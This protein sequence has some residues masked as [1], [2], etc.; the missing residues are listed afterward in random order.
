MG[1]SFSFII[2]KSFTINSVI[3][4]AL[5]SSLL[6][7]E[8]WL[9]ENSRW[10]IFDTS[11]T[12]AIN[13]FNPN[14]PDS[15][16]IKTIQTEQCKTAYGFSLFQFGYS[17]ILSNTNGVGTL[18]ITNWVFQNFFYS[19]NSFVGLLNGH[20][21]VSIIG[22]TFIKFS[23]WGSIIRDTAEYPSNLD[24]NKSGLNSSIAT[25]FR[26][27]MFTSDLI[28]NKLYVLPTIS[29]RDKTWASI[30]VE[31]STFQNF[32]YMKLGGQTYHKVSLNSNMRFQGIIPYSTLSSPPLCLV[33]LWNWENLGLWKNFQQKFLCNKL[34]LWTYCE[35]DLLIFV[36]FSY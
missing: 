27:T 11:Y 21:K 16:D 24:Y 19:F 31:S 30:K 3:F 17:N 15:W 10:W 7:T 28:Q 8:K 5:D 18:T 26:D 32:N 34:C 33:P 9:R 6:P 35:L 1:S 20:G 14:P 22:S 23:N 2:P 12:L 25:T 4:D 29:C 36:C 13:I